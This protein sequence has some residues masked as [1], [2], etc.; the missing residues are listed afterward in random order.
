MRRDQRFI[1]LYIDHDGVARPA[2][3]GCYFGNAVGAAGMVGACHARLETVFQR[4]SDDRLMI[5]GDDDLLRAALCCLF[6]DS[7][8]HRLAGDIQQW[9]AG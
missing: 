9:F 4:S 5:R 3:L 7:Y 6:R 2:L 8:H 1:S